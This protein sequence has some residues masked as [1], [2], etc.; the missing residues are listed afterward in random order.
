MTGT[1]KT[2]GLV[3]LVGFVI[4]LLRRLIVGRKSIKD[5]RIIKDAKQGEGP[6]GARARTGT[7][8]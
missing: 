3:L 8:G 6:R 1:L 4:W 5:Y 7:S 2:V